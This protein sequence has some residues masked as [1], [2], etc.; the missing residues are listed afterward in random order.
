[1]NFHG[2]AR[3]MFKDVDPTSLFEFGVNSQDNKGTKA[4]AYI[5][6]ER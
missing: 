3:P 4:K 2:V 5:L 1:M 6:T